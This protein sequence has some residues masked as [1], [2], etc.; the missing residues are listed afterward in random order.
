MED[1]DGQ[2][3]FPFLSGAATVKLEGNSR[4]AY[5]DGV[6]ASDEPFPVAPAS[7]FGDSDYG[8]L[9]PDQTVVILPYG[10][11]GDD[12][13][14]WELRPRWVIMYDPNQDFLRRLEV[15]DLSLHFSCYR[16]HLCPRFIEPSARAW[17]CASTSSI[18][19][20][21][22]KNTSS[23]SESDGRRKPSKNSSVNVVCVRLWIQLTANTLI[24]YS[25]KMHLVLDAQP[26]S[27]SITA[28][29]LLSVASSRNA[30]GQT[31]VSDQPPTVGFSI[32]TN[33]PRFTGSMWTDS[34]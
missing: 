21:Q 27:Y 13:L 8:L 19:T 25:Q 23:C 4:G 31:V 16:V 15:R 28:E 33:I 2:L 9:P 32:I 11:D 5:A 26:V 24:L 29:R 20:R 18:I 34:C 17:H 6:Y 14:L 7:A 1:L 22:A 10:D 30:G 12:V 3:G